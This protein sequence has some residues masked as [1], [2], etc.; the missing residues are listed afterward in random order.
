MYIVISFDFMGSSDRLHCV[1]AD[2]LKA[3]H[4]YDTV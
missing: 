1:S 4:M 2:G 3:Q